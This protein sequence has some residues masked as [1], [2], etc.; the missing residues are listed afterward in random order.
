MPRT[1]G[2][3]S[4]AA[5]ALVA[6]LVGVRPLWSGGGLLCPRTAQAQPAGQHWIDTAVP[7]PGPTRSAAGTTGPRVTVRNDMPATLTIVTRPDGQTYRVGWGGGDVPVGTGPVTELVIV[8]HDAYWPYV[9]AITCPANDS[10]VRLRMSDVWHG[11]VPEGFVV[12]CGRPERDGVAWF[13]DGRGQGTEGA[14]G[15]G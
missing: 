9:Y 2:I 10:A 7:P 1:A 5:L 11:R 4:I 13:G 8:Y 3:L 15:R 14:R 12:R 6:G